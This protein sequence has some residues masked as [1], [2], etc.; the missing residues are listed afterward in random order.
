MVS[1]AIHNV[2]QG[3][4]LRFIKYKSEWNKRELVSANRFYPSSKLC[5]HCGHIYQGL[6][7]KER[8]WTCR[9]CNA[10]HDRDENACLNLFYYDEEWFIQN[11]IN[12][13]S[14]WNYMFDRSFYIPKIEQTLGINLNITRE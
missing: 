8:T 7:L 5:S 1:R 2:A 4:L 3:N 12:N 14:T 10:Q 11:C 6:S 9:S 13:V